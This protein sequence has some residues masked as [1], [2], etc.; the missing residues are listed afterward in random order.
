VNSLAC[1]RTRASLRFS[2]GSACVRPKGIL[3]PRCVCAISAANTIAIYREGERA[4]R[5]ELI[6][7]EA[8]IRLG[9]SKMTVARLKSG[10][11][12]YRQDR[13]VSTRP[14]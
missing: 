14:M 8:A 2:I 9:V 12:C 3:G 4:E 13:F 5:R 10:M 6:L 1:C 7:H 11:G